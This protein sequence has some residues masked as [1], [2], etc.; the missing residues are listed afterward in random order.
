[1]TTT[2]VFVFMITSS[3][4]KKQKKKADRC[5]VVED[6]NNGCYCTHNLQQL[7]HQTHPVRGPCEQRS[8]LCQLNQHK[9]A[10]LLL[11]LQTMLFHTQIVIRTL[12]QDFKFTA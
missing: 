2:V 1:M 8:S 5:Q 4:K 10:I 3:K 12:K 11:K 9:N 6:G 7:V